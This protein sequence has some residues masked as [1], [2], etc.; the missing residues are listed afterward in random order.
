MSILMAIALTGV[1]GSVEGWYVP[2]VDVLGFD[3][4]YLDNEPLAEQYALAKGKPLAFPEFGDAIGGSSD[5]ASAVF[6]RQFIAGL[7]DNTIA[8]A[9]YNNNG[10]DI[11]THPQTLAVLRAAA[12]S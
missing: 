4:Y 1:H 8:A 9:W 11:A 12:G 3:C 2:G 7:D 5:A 6:A 10:N